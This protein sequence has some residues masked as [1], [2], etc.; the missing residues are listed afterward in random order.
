MPPEA[1]QT[2][3]W[4]VPGV[5]SRAR[6]LTCYHTDAPQTRA[7]SEDPH[8]G[9]QPPRLRPLAAE[10]S[11]VHTEMEVPKACDGPSTMGMPGATCFENLR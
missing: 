11:G 9:Q 6:H 4:S 5:P 7:P 2:G 1:G 10:A 3:K 8:M